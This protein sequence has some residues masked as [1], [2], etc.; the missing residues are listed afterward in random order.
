MEKRRWGIA[1]ER[2][3]IFDHVHLIKVSC[4]MAKCRPVNFRVTKLFLQHLVEPEY[5]G[6]H[7][8]VH[9]D[10]FEKSAFKS[11]DGHVAERS[12]LG[13]SICSWIVGHEHGRLGDR[14]TIT[15]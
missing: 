1:G 10:V 8:W 2:I 6:K 7:F 15:P 5:P 14:C 9:A 3:E 4:L 12:R 11:F 13:H